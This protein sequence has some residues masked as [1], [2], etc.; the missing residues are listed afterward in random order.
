MSA[1]IW[2]L[3]KTTPS[4]FSPAPSQYTDVSAAAI[5]AGDLHPYSMNVPGYRA[6]AKSEAPVLYQTSVVF[7]PNTQIVRFA[8]STATVLSD[9]PF[10]AAMSS[11]SN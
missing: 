6:N 7:S 3:R 1:L 5:D 9:A 8:T 2:S 4:P 10:F 11:G